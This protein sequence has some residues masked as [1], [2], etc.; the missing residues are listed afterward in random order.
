MFILHQNLAVENVD[1]L[2]PEKIDALTALSA[3][4]KIV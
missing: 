1:G 4:I 2:L 3:R